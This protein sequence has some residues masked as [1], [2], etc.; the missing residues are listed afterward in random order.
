MSNTFSASVEF[1]DLGHSSAKSLA[2]ARRHLLP[3]MDHVLDQF[4]EKLKTNPELVGFFVSPERM[5]I[6]R[7][8][9]KAH[10][11]RLLS[12]EFDSEYFASIDRI[13]RR[14]AQ[15]NLPLKVYLGAYA[16]ASSRL[17]E[18]LIT[19]QST[20]RRA[21][22]INQIGGMVSAVNR[23]FAFDIQCVTDVTLRVWNEELEVAFEHLGHAIE[24]LEYGN[25]CY[26]IPGPEVSDYPVRYDPVRQKLN[27]AVLRLGGSFGQIGALMESLARKAQQISTM[28]EDHAAR[29]SSQAASLE[30]T[31]AAMQEIT[32]SVEASTRL[33]ESSQKVATAADLDLNDASKTVGHASEAMDG[34]RE[35]AQLIG[36]ITQMIEDIAF[37]TNL[38]ALNAG[39][40]AA[41]AGRAGAG[42][43]V[44][45]TEVR[46]L[47]VHAGDSTKQIKD[48]IRKSGE[49]VEMG[50]DL[51]N[52]TG[53]KLMNL[54]GKFNEV[55]GLA[56][57]IA[58]SASRQS[59]GITEI[60][61]AIS[62]LDKIT[63]Q[64]A[65]MVDEALHHTAEMQSDLARLIQM[66]DG[67]EF[68]AAHDTPQEAPLL[69]LAS[70]R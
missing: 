62:D 53:K 57:E 34:I 50:V 49:Q 21:L 4:Y 59:N 27:A 37:Q 16:F 60:N 52:K 9:Q 45:A 68:R 61:T 47:A 28:S 42:F 69:R 23:A 6:A 17:L 7:E 11:L 67:F 30:E 14:H 19:K 31:A 48:L 55:Q 24:Q 33:T 66:L 56:D 25:L 43:A 29:T 1:F 20:G 3:Y 5:Q 38:L 40:E 63:Q 26:E 35:S 51:V 46:S 32:R 65:A 2:A 70:S 8:A 12:G 18:I 39:V 41:R 10:W 36:R 54:V 13:G 44:V 15:I 22:A 58:Q 64:N